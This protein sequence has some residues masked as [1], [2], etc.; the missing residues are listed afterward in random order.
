MAKYQSSAPR[1]TKKPIDPFR[2]GW[3]YV[4][5]RGPDGKEI[6]EQVPLTEW[7]VLHPQEDDFIV[8]NYAHTRDLYYLF[9]AF[10]SAAPAQPAHGD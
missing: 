1:K 10:E 7:D 2:L 9:G 3:R 8:T 5:R 4:T 6:C